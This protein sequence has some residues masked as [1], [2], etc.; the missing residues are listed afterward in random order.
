MKVFVAGAGG[1][2][3]Q[4]LLPALAEAG[5]AVVAMSRTP[6]KADRIRAMG[7]EPVIADALDERAVPAAVRAAAPEVVIH[8]L[9]AI[10]VQANFRTLDRDFALTNRLRQEG[11]DY[12]LGAARAAGARRFLAQSFVGWTL[13][14][15]GGPVKTEE[16]ALDPTPA[17]SMWATVDTIR[18][19]ESTLLSAKDLECLALR[20]GFLYGPGSSI[21][22]GGAV[23]ELVRRRQ[24]H[25]GGAGPWSARP[26]Q[27]RGRRPGAG[28]AVAARSGRGRGGEAALAAPPL[29]GPAG[30]RRGDRHHD[31]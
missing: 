3:G 10:P 21:A 4:H 13:A 8:Q 2:I 24:C 12:L 23:T 30:R 22:A 26:L 19:L 20:Y 7:A 5:H 25:P 14:R 17:R 15:P 18:H 6:G 11:L 1:A 27:R 16:D 9:T 29:P 28:G 31:E